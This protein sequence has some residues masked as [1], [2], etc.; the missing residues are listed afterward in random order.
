L[1]TSPI[2]EVDG[3]RLAYQRLSGD[4]LDR[5]TVGDGHLLGRLIGG[6][7]LAARGVGRWEPVRG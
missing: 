2:V 5:E 4:E 7:T 3:H 1:G 6:E